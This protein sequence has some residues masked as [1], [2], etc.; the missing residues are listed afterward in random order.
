MAIAE[1]LGRQTREG[2]A[3][4]QVA[5]AAARSEQDDHRARFARVDCDSKTRSPAV[6]K[7]LAELN[8]RGL[9]GATVLAIR[10]GEEAVLVPSGHER[11]MVGD[12]LAV[13]GTPRRRRVGQATPR[14]PPSTVDTVV[15][16]RLARD[17]SGR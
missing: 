2:R 14:P 10:R 15:V 5:A 12:V 9:T 6:G 13:A 16:R 17:D 11:L 7:T 4:V 3:D 1:S 8:L